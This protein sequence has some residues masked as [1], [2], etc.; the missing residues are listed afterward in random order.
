MISKI[1]VSSTF[2]KKGFK[3]FSD[4]KDG[5]KVRAFCILLPKMSAERRNYD[6]TKYMC[7]SIKKLLIPRKT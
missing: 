5:K 4:Y 3:F 7:F 2:G 6:E 1:V